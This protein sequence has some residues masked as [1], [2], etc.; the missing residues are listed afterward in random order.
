MA[1]KTKTT[2]CSG[3][4]AAAYSKISNING[5]YLTFSVLYFGFL[6]LIVVM[7][8]YG[9]APWVFK[10]AKLVP[11]GDKICHIILMGILSYLVNSTI[12]C[13][14]IDTLGGK[15][16]LGSA[17]VGLVVI[18]EEFSQVFVKSRNFELLD[19]LFDFIGIWLFGRLAL[20][21]YNRKQSRALS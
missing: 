19:L 21:N 13:K 16:L 20:I 8:N 9:I 4:N 2:T 1:S 11:F 6:T 14:R 12:H 10:A 3:V 15:I 17:G 7:A 5:A 18:L